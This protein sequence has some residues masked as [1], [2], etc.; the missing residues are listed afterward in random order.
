[1]NIFLSISMAYNVISCKEAQ[2]TDHSIAI[3]S[4]FFNRY[5]IKKWWYLVNPHVQTVQNMYG[6]GV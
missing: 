1:M 2:K 3:N 4:I 6:K 5:G